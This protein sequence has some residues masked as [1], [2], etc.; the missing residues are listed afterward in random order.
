MHWASAGALDIGGLGPVLVE[1][2]VAG[3]VVRGPVDLYKLSEADLRGLVGVGERTARALLAEIDES[4]TRANVD[5]ARLLAGL[6]LPGVGRETA[7]LLAVAFG[8]LGE[9][10]KAD[11][12]RLR[13]AGLGEA[14]A[15]GVV[16]FLAKPEVRAEWAALQAAGVG[17]L[18]ASAGAG[19]G[20]LAGQVVV[21]TGRLMR[22]TRKQ[23]EAELSAAGARV[24]QGV[25]GATTLVVAGEDP[26]ETLARAKARGVEVID[27]VELTR[28]LAVP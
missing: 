26:G 28:R 5:G 7:R 22:G 12:A 23:V 1:R 20:I 13:S 14:T 21:V 17:E 10:A 24:V 8:G 4:R 6:G 15:R 11:E 16:E 3:G 2:M 18:W 25:T 19:G 27:E 9:L